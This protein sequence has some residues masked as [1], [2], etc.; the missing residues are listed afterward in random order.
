MET[1]AQTYAVELIKAG[2]QNG[3]IKLTGVHSTALDDVKKRAEAD[4]MYLLQ[5]FT[6]LTTGS[7]PKP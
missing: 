4:G 5:L 7:M 3:T 6:L 1:L 2:L